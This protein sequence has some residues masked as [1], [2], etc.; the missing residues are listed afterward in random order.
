MSAA[1][2]ES[3]DAATER[4]RQRFD[5]FNSEILSELLWIVGLR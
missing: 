3:T 2:T 5:I 1:L 4:C